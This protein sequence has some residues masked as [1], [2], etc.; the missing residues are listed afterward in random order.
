MLIMMERDTRFWR[1]AGPIMIL[2]AKS[3]SLR[4][5]LLGFVFFALS[6][7]ISIFFFF[8]YPPPPPN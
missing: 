5:S 3:V 4:F 8:F 6:F 2:G 1:P 7:T